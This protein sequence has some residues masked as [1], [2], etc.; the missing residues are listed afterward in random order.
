MTKYERKAFKLIEALSEECTED[1]ETCRHCLAME[2]LEHKGTRQL[3]RHLLALRT[4]WA[5]NAEPFMTWAQ[6][7]LDSGRWAGHDLFDAIRVEM[8]E[9]DAQLA[10]ARHR[11]EG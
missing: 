10:D 9:R 5:E 1:W 7:Y 6:S 3:L 2:E 11:G 4:V 8:I